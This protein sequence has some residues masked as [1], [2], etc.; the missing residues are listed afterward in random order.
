MHRIGFLISDGFQI[1]ALAS[2]SVF[3]YANMAAGEPFYVLGNFSVSGAEVRSSL[4]FSVGTRS[5]R[6]RGDVDTWM[7]AGVND[8]VSSPAPAEVV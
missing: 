1:M 6:G 4:G 5:L 8:P 3:E 2:Q 7:V